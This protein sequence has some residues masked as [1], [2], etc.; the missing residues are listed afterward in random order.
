MSA[1]IRTT[2]ISWVLHSLK[3]VLGDEGIRRYVILHYHPKLKN[4]FKKQIRT[5]DA[6]IKRGKTQQDKKHEI[7]KYLSSIITLKDI[8]VFT[9]TNIQRDI[10]DNETHFQSYIV[11]NDNKIAYIIDPA[12]NKNGTGIYH[13]EISI[14]IIRPFF[15]K[16]LYKVEFVKLSS[17]AQ[18]NEG[19]VF[20]QTW[21]LLI[22]LELLE[23]KKY[24][25]DNKEFIIPKKQADKY[26]MI[27]QFY[28]KIFNELPDLRDNLKIEYE[29]EIKDCRGID[30]PTTA[31]KIELLKYDT[32]KLLLSMKTSEMK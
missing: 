8:V 9:A 13:P 28:K 15:E 7:E 16:H 10:F 30:C 6:F 26:E 22:L 11:D 19:D 29:G 3:I 25:N 24:N 4:K 18:V 20:C 2:A 5:F 14:E 12:F 17:P 21:S 31:D 1:K 23:D 32:V 27:L